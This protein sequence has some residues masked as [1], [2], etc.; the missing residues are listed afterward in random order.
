M[1]RIGGPVERAEEL[2]IVKELEK[3]R[4]LDSMIKGQYLNWQKWPR[5]FSKHM[6]IKYSILNY[7]FSLL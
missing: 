3:D 4:G 6:E 5:G 1:N 7:I 2:G